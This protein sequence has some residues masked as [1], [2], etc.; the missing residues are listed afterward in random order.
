MYL[1]LPKSSYDSA[2]SFSDAMADE[3]EEWVLIACL[4]DFDLGCD[5]SSADPAA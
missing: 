4:D 1:G 5:F 2:T 3:K